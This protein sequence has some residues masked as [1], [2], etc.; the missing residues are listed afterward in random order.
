MT[1][2]NANGGGGL[3]GTPAELNAGK[4]GCLQ[5]HLESAYGIRIVRMTEL[6]AGVFRVDRHD[7]PGWVA[8]VFPATRTARIRGARAPAG[9]DQGSPRDLRPVGVCPWP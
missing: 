7:G 3:A 5:A 9:G 4:A 1:V 6:D 8:R 2:H